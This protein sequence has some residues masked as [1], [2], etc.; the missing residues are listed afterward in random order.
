MRSYSLI[1]NIVSIRPT[2]QGMIWNI[3]FIAPRIKI[4]IIF[5]ILWS[6]FVETMSDIQILTLLK[7]IETSLIIKVANS[8]GLSVRIT[9]FDLLHSLTAVGPKSYGYKIILWV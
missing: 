4:I 3:L 7:Q 5:N 6:E 1:D 9:E 2:Q 8:Y